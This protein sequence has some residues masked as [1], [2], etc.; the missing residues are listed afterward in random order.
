MNAIASMKKVEDP[1]VRTIALTWPN[2]LARA[3]LASA[4]NPMKMFETARTGP[5]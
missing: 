1:V 5:L 2:L 3:G 4:E